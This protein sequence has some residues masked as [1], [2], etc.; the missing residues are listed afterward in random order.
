L[1]KRALVPYVD[2][3]IKEWERLTGLEMETGDLKSIYSRDIN[4]YFA[5][6]PDGSVKRKGEYSKAGLN[7]KKNPDVEICGD[8]VSAFLAHNTPLAQTITTCRDIRKFV[9]VQKV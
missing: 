9:V 1:C 4:N 7:E 2:Q 8:A 6:K 5:I 3:R